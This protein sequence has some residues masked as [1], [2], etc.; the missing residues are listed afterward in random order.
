MEDD[1]SGAERDDGTLFDT[2]TV[3]GTQHLIHDKGTGDAFIIA[4]RIDVIVILPALHVNHTVATVHTRVIR[5][6]GKGTWLFNGGTT[7]PRIT[8]IPTTIIF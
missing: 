6:D 4:Y 5:L 3:F 1:A 2:S 7:H 8:D